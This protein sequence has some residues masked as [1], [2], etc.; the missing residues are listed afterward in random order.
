MIRIVRKDTAVVPIHQ[1]ATSWATRKG[2]AYIPR[3]DEYTL[4]Q[5]FVAP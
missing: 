2:I 1:Q 5:Q 3:T 4:S